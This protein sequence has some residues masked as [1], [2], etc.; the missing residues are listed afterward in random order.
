MGATVLTLLFSASC[1]H[2][3][4]SLTQRSELDEAVS[5][6]IAELARQSKSPGD[7][8]LIGAQRFYDKGKYVWRITFKLKA[9]LPDDPS[10]QPIG[11]GGETFILVDLK[12]GETVVTLGE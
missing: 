7:H 8:K 1:R 5:I 6:G 9:L 10:T 3:V 11:A 2:R 12:T 4:N